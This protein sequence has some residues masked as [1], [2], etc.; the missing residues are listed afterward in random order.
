MSA[1][2]I[3]E[4]V[5]TFIEMSISCPRCETPVMING[6][7]TEIEC[8]GCGEKID[9]SPSIWADLLEDTRDELVDMEKG[10]GNNSTIWGT[11]NTSISTGRLAPYCKECKKD[12]DIA[13]DYSGGDTITCRDCGATR[14]AQQPPEWFDK[15]F[16]GVKLLI[17][18]SQGEV[19]YKPLKRDLYMSCPSCG[20]S[21][22]VS[23]SS[24]NEICSHCNSPVL[25]PDELWEHLHPVP[26]KERWFVGFIG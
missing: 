4:M 14:S 20:A 9:F 22:K 17:G 15:V 18:V 5:W 26:V 8:Q 19:S 24:R 10:E 3:E 11:Y 23:G 21:V 6:P 1:D 7:F 25:L 12:Y 16:E 13:A 2:N